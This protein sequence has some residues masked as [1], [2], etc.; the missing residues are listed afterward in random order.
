MA[1]SLHVW[2]RQPIFIAELIENVVNGGNG[3]WRT[4]EDVMTEDGAIGSFQGKDVARHG[5]SW[6]V[7]LMD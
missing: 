1:H 3:E 5:D 4:I 2:Q 7:L 6:I